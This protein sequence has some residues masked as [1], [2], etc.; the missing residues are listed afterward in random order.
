MKTASYV[1]SPHKGAGHRKRLRERFL[2]SGLYGFNDYEIIELLLTLGT[3]LKDCK[4]MAKDAIA[5]FGGLRG[6]LDASVEELQKIK[7]IGP[8]NAFGIKLFQAVAEKL[9]KEQL[10]D[11]LDLRSSNAVVDYLQKWIGREKKENFVVLYLDSQDRLIEN[12]VISIGILNG[13]LVHPREVFQPAVTLRSLS[14]IVAHNHPSGGVEPSSED[15]EITNKLVE[16]GRIMEIMVKDHIIVSSST[17][18]SFQQQLL[19]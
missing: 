3:P 19:I 4:Q 18:F 13:A 15:R 1:N 16:T 6:A 14:I 7:G 8:S 17:Y 10:R 11:K 2:Q 9:A 5:E 12:R